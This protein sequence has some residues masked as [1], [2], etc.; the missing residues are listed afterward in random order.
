MRMSEPL[1]HRSASGARQG[2]DDYQHLVAWNRIL[3]GLMSGR[4]MELVELEAVEA[5]NVDDVVIHYA[6]QP[7][8]FAQVRYAVDGSSPLNSA[9]LTRRAAA[10]GTTMLQKFHASWATLRRD[11]TPTLMLITNRLADSADP[12]FSVLDGRT[13]LLVPALIRATPSSPLGQL[14]AQWAHHLE[15]DDTELADLLSGIRFR[16][17][18][19]YRAE[20]ELAE[21]LMSAAGLRSDPSAIRLGIDR[22][23]RW[24]LEGNRR[25]TREAVV[26]GIDELDLATGDPAAVLHVQAL[27]RDPTASEATEALD[28]V[29]LYVGDQPAERR[30]ATTSDAYQRVMQPQLDAAAGR[31]LAA[32]YGRVLVRGAMRLPAQFAV[33]AALPKVRNVE[34]V[35]RQGTEIWKTDTRSEPRPRLREATVVLGQGPDI[36]VVVGITND[37]TDDVVAFART[38]RLP[39][40]TVF[41]LEPSGDPADDAVHGA[42]H[43]IGVVQAVRDAVRHMLRQHPD[44]TVHLF[45]SCPGALAMFLGHRWNRVART[46][47]YEDLKSTYQAAFIVAA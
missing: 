14:R 28:W 4:R 44:A 2:G 16:L 47:I 20:E 19:P 9:Y 12:A 3:R 13:E 43:A 6:D 22:V 40:D 38:A 39:V 5:G 23:R 1:P 33:G 35:R 21:D 24:V 29:D 34:L 27:L 10:H 37:P 25:L 18:R 42:G 7:N 36:A 17:G 46:V 26:A 11:D 15:C 30:V 41:V 31:L 32:G 45:L 8:E